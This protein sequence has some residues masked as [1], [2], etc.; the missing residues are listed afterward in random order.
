MKNFISSTALTIA[1]VLGLTSA[2]EAQCT[3]TAVRNGNFFDASTWTVTPSSSGARCAGASAPVS[4]SDATIIINGFSV[5]LNGNYLVAKNGSIS[6]TGGGTLIGGA[7]L[8]LGDGT[9]GPTDTGLLIDAGSTLRVA[10]LT[11]D[12]AT[13]QVM[14]PEVAA[15]PPALLSTDCNLVLVNSNIIDNSRVVVNG[16]IDLTRGGSNN[17]LCGTGSVRIA[18]CVFGGNGAVS[19]LANNCASALV[20][21]CAQRVTTGCPGP[22]LA[23]NA[24]ETECQ[25]LAV[26]RPLP[27]ELVLFTASVTARQAVALHWVTASERNSKQF[28]I[29]RSADGTSFSTLRTVVAAGTTSARTT[30]DQ[31]DEQPL[32]GT[33]YYRLRQVDNDGTTAFSPVQV[34]RMGSANAERLAVYPGQQAQQWVVSHLAGRNTGQRTGPRAG[35]RRLGPQPAGSVHP[36]CQPGRPMGTRPALTAHGHVHCAAGIGGR[37]VQPAHCAIAPGRCASGRPTATSA[38]G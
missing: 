2:S 14:A 23:T 18:G 20:T 25:S 11:I 34:V 37:R 15:A 32:F 10:Q 8:L 12:K 7:D 28:V 21:V 29:E 38:T 31:L 5:V 24:S 26:C 16:S 36:R 6:L 30:Y 19:K 1:I 35:A 4:G 9:G 3:Y 27:V 33:S 17:T 13:V 22:I